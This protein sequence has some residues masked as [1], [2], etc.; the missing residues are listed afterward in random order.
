[1]RVY[2][3]SV[4]ACPPERVWAEVQTPRLL[5]EII[6]P[7]LRFEPVDEDT[8]PQTWAEGTTVRLRTYAFRVL[9]LGDHAIHV[10][11][12]DPSHREIQT[13]EHSRLIR[14]W[15]HRI[16]VRPTPD[17][18]TLYSDEIDIDAGLL[19]PLVWLFAQGLY[20]HRQRGWRRVARRLA[21]DGRPAEAR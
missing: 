1:M 14:R 13:R 5:L 4:L 10:E 17:G 15:D 19:T 12:V 16:R 8:F 9:P 6:D 3:E 20:R 18:H 7:L 11:R 21:R 2:V